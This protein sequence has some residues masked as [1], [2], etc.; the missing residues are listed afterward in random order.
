MWLAAVG[1]RAELAMTPSPPPGGATFLLTNPPFGQHTEMDWLQRCIASLAEDGR[2]A[3]L[4]PYGAGFDPSAKARDVRRELV[5]DGAVLTV[6]ALPARMFP[7]LPSASVS[8]CCDGR[9][10]MLRRCSSWTHA[11]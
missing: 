7:G 5:D 6:V 4:M 10:D 8:G 2:A 3:V 1:V 11:N 9:Q